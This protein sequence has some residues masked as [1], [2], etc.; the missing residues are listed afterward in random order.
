[1]RGA[2][3]LRGL[4]WRRG[5]GSEGVENDGCGG[6]EENAVGAAMMERRRRVDVTAGQPGQ[7]QVDGWLDVGVIGVTTD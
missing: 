6:A 4:P 5:P 2:S 7:R 3:H 1:M